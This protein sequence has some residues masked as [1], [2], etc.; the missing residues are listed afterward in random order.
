MAAG[1]TAAAAG[2]G[3]A[4]TTARPEIGWPEKV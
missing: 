3:A 2:A 4:A 1:T